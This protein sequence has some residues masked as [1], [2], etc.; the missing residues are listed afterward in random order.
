MAM[1]LIF[2]AVAHDGDGMALREGLK[3]SKGEFLSVVFDRAVEA[4]DGAAF[5]QL[6]PVSLGEF[7]PRQSTRLERPEQ[8]FA[9]TEVGHPDVIARFAQATASDA[10][11][12]DSQAVFGW[13]DWA[14]D[15]F[16]FDHAACSKSARR[17]FVRRY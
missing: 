15:G 2:I 13:L 9:R 3:K 6:S 16:G 8:G 1:R 17:T 5:K 10:S 12:Q 4:V 14:I 11:G 7:S